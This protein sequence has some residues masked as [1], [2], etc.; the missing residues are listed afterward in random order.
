MLLYDMLNDATKSKRNINDSSF[1]KITHALKLRICR[2]SLNGRM[3]V[4]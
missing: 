3:L 1:E 2:N 4:M